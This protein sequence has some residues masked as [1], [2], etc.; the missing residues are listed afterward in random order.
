MPDNSPL[1]RK[2]DCVRL[3]VADLE[4]GLAFY[5]DALGHELN[6]RTATSAGLRMPSSDAEIVIHTEG[7]P[8]EVDPLVDSVEEAARR[9]LA[10]GGRVVA[11]PFDIAIG[12]CAVVA[13]PWGNELVML[14][15]S[16]GRLTTDADGN[17]TG[18]GPPQA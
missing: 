16:K 15:M 17:V 2:V 9:F 18:D 5:R 10:A 7:Q 8:P 4:S 14:D 13:D 3:P 6:W 1:F 11:G 12:R